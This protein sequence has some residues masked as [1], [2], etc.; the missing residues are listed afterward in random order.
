MQQPILSGLSENCETKPSNRQG[1][2][3][4]AVNIAAPLLFGICMTNV[5]DRVEMLDQPLTCQLVRLSGARLLI[6]LCLCFL[7][8]CNADNNPL[9]ALGSNSPFGG[10]TMQ[11]S[12]VERRGSPDSCTVPDMNAWVYRNMLDYYL[13]YDQVERNLAVENFET[14]ESLVEALRVQPQDRFSY[15]TDENTYE[16]FFNEGETFGFGWSV[17]RAQDNQVYFSLIDPGSPLALSGIE[18]GDRLVSINQM[19]IDDFFALR[20]DE[21]SAIIGN[22]GEPR[23]LSLM[24]ADENDTSRQVS[25]TSS[26]YAVETVLNNQVIDRNGVR[27]GYLNFY[28]F[29]N[30][31][32]VDLRE[33]FSTLAAWDIDELILD[34]R[35]NSGGRISVANELASHILGDGNT[36]KVFTTLAYND[37][38]SSNNVSL[39]F[40]EMSNKL[41]LYRV[42]VL[43]SPG[44]CSASELVIN[45]LRPFMEVI[46]IGAS[47]CG[48]PYG[49]QPNAA[50]GKVLNA[51][52]IDLVNADG[53]GGYY[54]GILADCP[55]AED[56]SIALGHE[57]EPLLAT[58]L[59]YINQG[60]CDQISARLSERA[61]Q[62]VSLPRPGWLGGNAL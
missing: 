2:A 15:M 58:A 8:A 36:D 35:F 16:A 24:V 4:R 12:E 37:Q 27:I 61:D 6:S 31:A 62:Q 18:R 42:F 38:Y 32:S 34:L 25:V 59:G 5:E 3:D 28:S 26:T 11:T 46:T 56:V 54:D 9:N 23:T 30:S 21:K 45:G 33:A 17:S 53:L 52:E 55:I 20:S 39:S 47:S 48:K 14:S 13:F 57:E 50:C 1:H 29:I 44:T 40:L 51:L 41:D 10:N 43:Q 60:Y 7:A 49:S 22:D 19:L